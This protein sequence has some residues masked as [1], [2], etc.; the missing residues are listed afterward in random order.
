MLKQNRMNK[1][2]KMTSA[3]NYKYNKYK[4]NSIGNKTIDSNSHK[5]CKILKKI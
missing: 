1:N 3:V 2:L 5:Q 4:N